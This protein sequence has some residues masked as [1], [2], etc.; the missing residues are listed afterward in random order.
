[1][2]SSGCEDLRGR[3]AESF[4]Y[5][6]Y[7]SNLL[8]ERIHL[9]NPSAAFCCVARL[10]VSAPRPAPGRGAHPT[11]RGAG[12]QLCPVSA[13]HLHGAPPGQ[14]P[15][16][17]RG[18][19]LAPDERCHPSNG[20]PGRPGSPSALLACPQAARSAQLWPSLVR[21]LRGILPESTE[22]RPRSSFL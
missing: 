20:A 3:E 5:F 12:T 10:Q 13:A 16:V 1:M 22:F 14:A 11:Y 2:A 6:A 15:L 19:V 4:L 17:P 9:R 8:T 21:C 7:G 18:P